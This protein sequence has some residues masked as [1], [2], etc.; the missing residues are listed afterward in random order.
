MIW[1]IKKKVAIRNDSY[2]PSFGDWD[3]KIEENLKEGVS[4]ANSTCNF[5]S[6]NNLELIGGKGEHTK[7]K[8]EDLEVYKVIF[9]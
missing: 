6:N 1:S 8:V 2:G 9:Y 4:Y 3:L 7:F 5:F